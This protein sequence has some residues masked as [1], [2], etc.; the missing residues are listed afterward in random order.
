MGWFLFVWFLIFAGA[1]AWYYAFGPIPEGTV[2][3]AEDGLHYRNEY[4]AGYIAWNETSGVEM[5]RG[6]R[7]KRLT[8]YGEADVDFKNVPAG[9]GAG[10]AWPATIFLLIYEADY[11]MKHKEPPQGAPGLRLN[12]YEGRLEIYPSKHF[13]IEKLYR[14]L[15][16]KGIPAMRTVKLPRA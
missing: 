7:G 11:Q 16:L 5:Y 4:Y 2:E 10:P 12:R 14:D 15:L 13:D 6:W 9:V 3:L 8:V 1:A